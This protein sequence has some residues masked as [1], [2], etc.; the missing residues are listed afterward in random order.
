[1]HVRSLKNPPLVVGLHPGQAVDRGASA[2]G[3]I[4]VAPTEPTTVE[5]AT[6]FS[7]DDVAIPATYNLYLTMTQPQ[8]YAGN[9]VVPLGKMGEPD[10]WQQRY[11]GTVIRDNG[12]FRMWY[13][14]AS[15]EGFIAPHLGG[16]DLDFRGWRFAYAESDDGVNWRKP[17]LG[18]V[19]FRGSRHNNLVLM[20]E[21]FGGYH[22]LVLHEPEDPDPSRR[23][24]MM[25]LVVEPFGSYSF[26]AGTRRAFVPLYSPDGLRW[27][28]AE[29]LP[30]SSTKVI[31]TDDLV[32]VE[33]AGLFK[34]QGM[35]YLTGQGGKGPAVKPYERH[36]EIFRSPDLI[37]WS[38]TQTMGFARQGQFRRPTHTDPMNNEQTHEGVSVWNRGNVLIGLTGFWHGA[39]DWDDVTHDLGL[40]ISNDA[41]HFREPIP[42][43]IFASAGK[44]GEWDE[45]GLAQGEGFENV[46]DKTYIWY[47]Q[48]DQREGPRRGLPIGRPWKRWGGIGLLILER[49]RFGSLGVR[50]PSD[51]GILVT[52]E[53]KSD[54][55]PRIWVNAQGLAPQSSLRLELLDRRERPLPRYSGE[56]AAIVRQ[57]GLRV[58][59]SWQG[60]E[61]AT[62]LKGPF[63]IKVS[64]E[65]PGKGAIDLYA[66]YVGR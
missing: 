53:L 52:S 19:D 24:K 60:Q 49:D 59:V 54:V 41:L 4:Y 10:E 27:R 21:G 62:D 23:Y 15:K 66:I 31:S 40:L 39:S 56:R 55:P 26:K 1:M 3:P 20:P 64:F 5:E 8:K 11:Y 17:D 42:D 57:S 43:H 30:V 61:Q 58:P 18:L 48:M 51:K 45:A 16:N 34:W 25:A 35:Y 33:G 13:I 7:F 28:L 50:D 6:L 14:A 47:A 29:E 9:P 22:A 37:H 44:D 46:G 65:G 2:G 36:I 38:K 12:K 63:K 32:T